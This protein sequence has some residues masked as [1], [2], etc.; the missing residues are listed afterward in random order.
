MVGAMSKRGQDTTLEW[1]VSGGKSPTY[2]SGDA[3]SV[4]RGRLATQI[5]ISGQSG[6]S[7]QQKKELA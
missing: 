1:W 7:Q 4:Q 3:R 2:Q 6:E 5:G